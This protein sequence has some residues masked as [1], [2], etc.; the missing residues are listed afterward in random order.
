MYTHCILKPYSGHIVGLI[1]VIW[2][3]KVVLVYNAAY[4]TTYNLLEL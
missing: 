2:S 1:F 4:D 3:K